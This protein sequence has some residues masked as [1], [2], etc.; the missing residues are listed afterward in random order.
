MTK[1]RTWTISH[2]LKGSALTREYCQDP[3]KWHSYLRI[4]WIRDALAHVYSFLQVSQWLLF[5]ILGSIP[6]KPHYHHYSPFWNI[7]CHNPWSFLKHISR[8]ARSWNWG[9]LHCEW[10]Q[11]TSWNQSLVSGFS[12]SSPVQTSYQQLNSYRVHC[13]EIGQSSKWVCG[14]R[15]YLFPKVLPSGFVVSLELSS[16][17]LTKCIS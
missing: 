11:H 9:T 15:C 6:R 14:C 2:S 5:W 13:C 4:Q 17:M 1:P 8:H 10:M 12:L 16:V 3:T 7:P